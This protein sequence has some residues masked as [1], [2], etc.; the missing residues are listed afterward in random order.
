M[1]A[2]DAGFRTFILVR[3]FNRSESWALAAFLAPGKCSS[4]S[5]SSQTQHSSCGVPRMFTCVQMQAHMNPH[6]LIP[7]TSLGKLRACV[8]TGQT[9][10]PSECTL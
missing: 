10:F 9:L 8:I 1:D 4:D 6:F 5:Q 2:V 7:Q 3:Q